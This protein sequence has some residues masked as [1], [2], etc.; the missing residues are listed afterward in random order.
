M[1]TLPP[2]GLDTSQCNWIEPTPMVFL[3][4]HIGGTFMI[5]PMTRIFPARCER[6][7]TAGLGTRAQA[8]RC[9]ALVS[10]ASIRSENIGWYRNRFVQLKIESFTWRERPWFGH[11]LG[12]TPKRCLMARVARIGLWG[13]PIALWLNWALPIWPCG[14]HSITTAHHVSI[15]LAIWIHNFPQVYWLNHHE[16]PWIWGVWSHFQRLSQDF[17]DCLT[18]L[19]GSRELTKRMR[20]K[21]RQER[22]KGGKLLWVWWKKWPWPFFDPITGYHG[23]GANT[24]SCRSWGFCSMTSFCESRV[25]LGGLVH[26]EGSVFSPRRCASSRYKFYRWSP[27][28][29]CEHP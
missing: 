11:H 5:Q 4:A 2:S 9:V 8:F 18:F 28:P 24:V 17:Q 20:L 29:A 16:S 12:N 25:I 13:W 15:P 3:S 27:K 14:H 23:A 7:A 6:T 19:K 21:E 26:S 22:D 1:W 10:H